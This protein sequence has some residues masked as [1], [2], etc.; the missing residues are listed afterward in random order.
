MFTEGIKETENTRIEKDPENIDEIEML[1]SFGVVIF[2]HTIL[3]SEYYEYSF[4]WFEPE[5]IF[6]VVIKNKNLQKIKVFKTCSKLDDEYEKLFQLIKCEEIKGKNNE[7]IKCISHS[8][9]YTL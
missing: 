5:K 6:D 4:C 3:E 1:Y 8:I 7:I 9:E 2:E